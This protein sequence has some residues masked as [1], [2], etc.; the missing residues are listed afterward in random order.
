MAEITEHLSTALADR[1]RIERRLGEGGMATVYL[2]E[3]LKHDRKV[4]L[5]VLRPELGA[6]LG[7]DRFVQEIKTTAQLQ[8]PH[9]LPLYDSGSTTA[10]HGGGT[11][12]LYYVMPYIQGETLRERLNREQQ[13][14]I[15]EAVTITTEVA[16]ALQYAHEQ[17]VIHRDI[18]PENILLRNGRAI[19]A[20]FG[21][22]LAVS[23]AAGGRMTETGLSLGTPRY[24]SPEQATADKHVTNRSDIYSLGSV[25]YELLTGDPPHTGSSAQVI[26]LKI[27]S[28]VAR[29]VRELRRAVPPHV[30]AALAMALEK[31]PADRFDSAKA[32]AD[33]LRNPAFTLPVATAKTVGAAGLT[34]R[35]VALPALVAFGLLAIAIAAW[36]WIRPSRTTSVA[37]YPTTLGALG[38]LDG[39][40][41]AVEA[42]LSPDG[43][44]LVFRSP[45][46]GP[47]QLYVKRRDE[48]VARPLS[49]T[50]GGS[51]PFF[52]PD[53]AWIGFVANGQLR[54]IPSTGGASLKLADSV[55]PTYNRAAWLEDG[56]IVYYD[57]T[58]RT[59]RRLGSG[60]A[61]SKV[62]V[63]SAMLGGRFPWLPTPLPA[64]RGVLFTAHLTQCVGPSSCRPSR[65]YV[66]DVRRDTVRALFDDAIGAW[67]VPTGH[68]LYLTSAGTLMAAPWD[69]EALAP[70]GRP[71][72]VL[73]GIQAP[74]FLVSG[75][76]TA[77]Y[78]LGRQQ[79]APAP[80][81]NAAVVWVDRTGHVEPVDSSWQVNTGG[82]YSGLLE[83]DWG[84]ALS[85]DGRRIALT[86]LTD[87]GTDIWIKQV[88][89][90]PVSRL[91]LHA[92]ADRSPSW[93]P[94]GR[95]ITFL[96]DR[97]I[98]TGTTRKVNPFNVWE[99]AA[100]GT[101]EPR[102]LWGK[103]APT[104]AFRSPDGRW[105]VLGATRSTG[106]SEQ[107]EILAAQPGVDS[108]AR[109]VV[110]TGY[111]ERG[112][113]LSPDSRWLA[114]V[115]NEQ[116]ANEVFVRPF[117]DVNGGKWQVSSGGGSA[118]LWAHNGRELFYAAN[119][120]MHVVRINPG[121]PFSAEPPRVLFTIPD[122]VRAGAVV[123]GTFAI[124]PDD[125][126]FLMVRD[127]SWG[128]MAGTPTLVVVQSFFDELRAKLK[129]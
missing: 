79:F 19:V 42:A 114:Y 67:Y 95:A 11:G 119:G 16:D 44:S 71:V 86:L 129:R 36:G 104:D 107:G 48:V 74:G 45:L 59:L 54:R 69:N 72:A 101:G 25:L 124:T 31:L 58:N 29:P 109:G 21:I 81:P 37:R 98:W 121:P 5:K 113:A 126:R 12:F 99:Q 105:I 8:H 35:R 55:D 24:M 94:D 50:E 28:D 57:A 1:Y 46:T 47:G 87:L 6:L 89:R 80:V 90:G 56:S 38:A 120:K 23:A 43:A 103:D 75:E 85:P 39:I 60:D 40:T 14:G 70:T 78:L 127:N 18:K 17:G 97:P 92:G 62:I 100:D 41:F 27:V 9:I 122:R 53:G 3:D 108:L 52:S 22:A 96:S 61:T 115:S 32:F 116:G 10:A 26:I 88:P 111:D 2:A 15:D 4:A 30:A 118:P 51:G 110:A 33:A 112:A 64:S 13:L 91:T 82:V 83:T 77:Y 66:F 123:R 125:Q 68:V 106:A 20:D 34:S 128:D 63:S 93:T 73:D 65:V 117:P 76:G 102:L 7:A 49:G 84:L